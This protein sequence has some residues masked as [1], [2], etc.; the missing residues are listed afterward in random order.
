MKLRY[1]LAGAVTIRAEGVKPESLLN[2]LSRKEI[3][4]TQARK[5][6]PYVLTFATTRAGAGA[7]LKTAARLGLDARVVCRKGL[8]SFFGRYKKRYILVYMPIILIFA[9]FYLS[10]FI[11]EIKIAGNKTVSEAEIRQALEEAGVGI[12]KN[13]MWLDN[14]IIR[15]KVLYRLK[16]LSWLTVRVNGSRALVIVRERRERPLLIDESI[17][18]EICAAKT[19]V[20]SKVTA[21]SGNAAV[22]AGDTVLKGQTLISGKLTDRQ[23]QTRLVRSMGEVWARTW[24][25]KTLKIPLAYSAKAYTGREKQKTAVN[26]CNLR[27][28]FYINSGISYA[29]YD[30]ITTEKR[31]SILG[32]SLPVSIIRSIYREYEALPRA[33]EENEAEELLKNRLLEWVEAETGGARLTEAAFDVAREDGWLAVSVM[34]ECYEQIGETRYY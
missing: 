30:K 29:K 3:D 11:W 17:P 24:Y 18:T 4:F 1:L 34:A 5:E 13:G 23:G 25:T 7:A 8:P 10:S 27:L 26:V 14:E 31:P 9:V 20:I 2:E 19:G 28:N 33:L 15:S 16:K 21:L 6:G 12:G 32:F 22:K